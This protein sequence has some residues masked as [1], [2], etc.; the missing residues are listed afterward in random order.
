[1]NKV[2][3]IMIYLAFVLLTGCSEKQPITDEMTKYDFQLPKS[4]I[5]IRLYM[6]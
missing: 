5:P 1:M 3:H 4:S 2:A 6:S